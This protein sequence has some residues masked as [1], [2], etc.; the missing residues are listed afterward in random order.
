MPEGDTIHKLAG[1]LRPA[2]Q[3]REL[4]AGYARTTETVDLAGSR[5]DRVYSRGKHLF[6]ELDDDRLLRSHLGMWGSWHV[7]A[8]GEP[9]QKPRRQGSI[10]LDTGERV[11][12]CFNAMEVEILRRAGVRRRVLEATLGPDL[13]ADHVSYADILLRARRFSADDTPILDVLLDQRV[14][15]GIGNVYKS[16]I[17]FLD[18]SHPETPLARVSDERILQIYMLASRLLGRNT[19]GGPRVTRTANDNAGSLWVY[20]RGGKPCLRCDAVIRATRLGRALRSTYWCPGCQPRGR[21]NR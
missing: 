6:I 17:L 19:R 13:L 20:G 9:W 3:G 15:C 4:L 14:A 10:V 7:Y 1:Y 2:L 8:P 18:G 21:L 11:F 16:E 12:V 5:M